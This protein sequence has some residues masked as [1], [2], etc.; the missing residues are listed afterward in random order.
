MA[1]APH[2]VSYGID[3]IKTL[4]AS[5]EEKSHDL[6]DLQQYSSK[7]LNLSVNSYVNYCRTLMGSLCNFLTGH[8]PATS[9][10]A[11]A[12]G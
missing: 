6:L 9:T 10:K 7:N 11:D 5:F 1:A 12:L 3:H 8:P 2:H 4:M